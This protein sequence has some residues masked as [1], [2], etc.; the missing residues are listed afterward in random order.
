M[1]PEIDA[2]FLPN[3]TSVRW[4]SFP[5]FMKRM[6][7][8]EEH[9]EP[10]MAKEWITPQEKRAV[11]CALV[12]YNPFCIATDVVQRRYVSYETALCAVDQVDADLRCISDALSNA[13]QTDEIFKAM[14]QVVFCVWKERK[15]NFFYTRAANLLFYLDGQRFF[16]SSLCK[17]DVL[18][19]CVKW[20]VKKGCESSST[21][22]SCIEQEHLEWDTVK[23]MAS[24]A[25]W[26]QEESSKFPHLKRF[27][28]ELQQL[29]CTE[30]EVER[31]FKT[32][33][34]VW[35][36]E[37]VNMSLPLLNCLVCLRKN[38]TLWQTTHSDSQSVNEMNEARE[39]FTK[40]EWTNQ[41]SLLLTTSV[42][43]CRYELR[44]NV[45]C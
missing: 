1:S 33:S 26:E 41:I 8:L 5:R 23:Q 16:K 24:F 43:R 10:L 35:T 13:K 18:D 28:I 15:E 19:L 45:S 22:R 27:V 17:T 6:L 4:N 40:S 9:I 39:Y 25:Y 21:L 20:C 12:F 32:A 42:D 44:S 3:P 37:R 14:L 36:D 2:S 38:V 7:E 29:F 34:Y 11:R 31:C 30:A